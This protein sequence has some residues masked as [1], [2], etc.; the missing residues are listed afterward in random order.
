MAPSSVKED[1]LRGTCRT[2]EEITNAYSVICAGTEE[3][4]PLLNL[5]T[6][7]SVIY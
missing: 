4:T 1:E 2:H 5:N 3:K 6:Y 7:M